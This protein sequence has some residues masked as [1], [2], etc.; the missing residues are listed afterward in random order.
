MDAFKEEIEIGSSVES[1]ME[2][3]DSQKVLFHSQIDQ[4]QD[5]VVTQCKL[6]GVNPLA[7]EMV[8]HLF[9]VLW[10]LKFV[11]FFWG[12]VI[13]SKLKRTSQSDLINSLKGIEYSKN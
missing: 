5:V 12:M 3:L 6:T 1:L 10:Y 8:G 2:L 4:L 11:F 13:C 7:Q 9:D